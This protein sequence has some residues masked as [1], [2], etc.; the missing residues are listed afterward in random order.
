[1]LHPPLQDDCSAH[2]IYEGFVAAGHFADA[3]LQDS[4][5]GQNAGVALVPHIDGYR[6]ESL[7]QL[8]HEGLDARQVLAIPSVCLSGQTHH[9]TFH[10]FPGKVV[11]QVGQKLWRFHRCQTSRN[12]LQRVR[13]SQTGA[14]DPVVYCQY[15]SHI[16]YI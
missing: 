10:L 13:H 11:F 3:T 15:S 8:C 7:L 5:L 14:T 6:W 4:L 16:I 2:L 12:N 1:M 9:E